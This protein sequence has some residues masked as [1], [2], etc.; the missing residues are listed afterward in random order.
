MGTLHAAMESKRYC[1]GL[2]RRREC[3]VPTWR[4]WVVLGSV[5]ALLALL[6]LLR[7]HPFLSLHAPVPA[8]LLIVEGWT[9]DYVFEEATREFARGGYGQVIVTGGPLERGGPLSEY[10]TYAELGA[11]TLVKMGMPTNVVVAV[12][13]PRVRQ[14]RTYSA[15]VAVKR[16]FEVQ[17]QT[18]EAANLISVGP[19]ARR[20]HL[21]NHRALGKSVRLGI[22]NVPSQDYDPDRWWS[23]SAGVRFVI[24]ETVAYFYVR[25]L[26]RP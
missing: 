3:A 12:P 4:G 26:F 1:C 24:N 2:L 17:G 9:A 20:S 25:L 5:A 21:L 18:P 23:S 16:W 15:A 14:D 7:I 6:A 8:K 11:A 10:R 19:H 22:I 13:S